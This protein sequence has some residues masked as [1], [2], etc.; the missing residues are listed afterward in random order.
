MSELEIERGETLSLVITARDKLGEPIDL[1]DGIQGT[2]ASFNMVAGGTDPYFGPYLRHPE[3]IFTGPPFANILVPIY[4]WQF[5]DFGIENG[6]PTRGS[7]PFFTVIY[8]EGGWRWALL[9]TA[10]LP[11]RSQWQLIT[12]AESTIENPV[13]SVPDLL[14]AGWGALNVEFDNYI[15]EPGWAVDSW[16]RSIDS[17]RFH[18]S[19]RPVIT[20]DGKAS[21]SY[22]TVRLPPGRYQFDLRFSRGGRDQFTREYLLKVNSTITPPSQRR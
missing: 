15:Y 2:L 5:A 18:E 1:A 14:N 17:P 12:Y 22:D 3:K 16:I 21:I 10:F 20:P 7:G 4:V 11:D 19:M 6:Q 8:H 9:N 13:F